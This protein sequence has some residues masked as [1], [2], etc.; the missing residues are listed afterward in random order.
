MAEQKRGS[1]KPQGVSP[2]RKAVSVI[3]LIVVLIVLGIE[4]RAGLGQSG[5]FK[6]LDSIDRKSVV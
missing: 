6:A 5:S 4:L 2:A 1:A 3:L